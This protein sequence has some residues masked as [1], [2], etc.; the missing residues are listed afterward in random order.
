M[1]KTTL[2]IV[3]AAL[4]A[5]SGCRFGGQSTST[6]HPNPEFIGNPP[7]DAYKYTGEPGV[8]GGTLVIAIPDDIRTFN[9]V[10]ASDTAT[11]DV[12]WLNVFRCPVDFRN[13]TT[14]YDSGLCTKWDISADATQWT[15]HFRRGVLWS[16]GQ[17]FTAD[18]VIFTYD[19]LKDENV[20]GPSRD[21]FIESIGDD[22]KPIFP[23][24]IKLDDYTV[25]FD[26]HRSNWNFLD[27]IYNLWLVAKHKLE[28]AFNAGKFGETMRLTDDPNEIVSLGPFRIKEY[29][30]GQRV[31]VERNP[32]FWKVDSRGQRLPYLDRIV[33]VI[34]KDFNT[35]QAKFEAGDLDVMPRV[36]P[37]DY[38][39]VKRMESDSVKIADVGASYDTYW[40]VFNQNTDHNPSTGKP[41]VEPWKLRLF[42]D[43]KFRQAI[44]YAIDREG[45]ANTAFSAR[46]TPLYSF[47]SPADPIWYSDDVM[48]YP[49]DPA[50]SRQMLAELD[51]KDNNG[52]GILEDSQGHPL[53]FTLVTNASNSQRVNSATFIAGNLRD[54][55]IKINTNP[56]AFQIVNNMIETSFNFDAVLLGWQINP[57]PGPTN[58]KN[59]LLSSG[60]QHV[61]FPLQKQPQRDW[62]ARI[63]ELMHS[64]ESKPD[65]AERRRMYAEVQRIWS[66]QL[67]EINLVAPLEGIAYRTRV[68]NLHASVL[69]PRTTWNSEELYIR[70]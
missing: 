20:H 7:Q 68:G 6:G 5:V 52:D 70:Q 31:V 35:V 9:I 17:P 56:V 2:T 65:L 59:I 49:F 54:V 10:M 46:A 41:Y 30:S 36:R 25:R 43:Q 48:K 13:D 44:S 53:E 39:A 42:R 23:D 66:E 51:L 67:P 47:V 38:A 60:Q 3:I 15:F 16:D 4:L 1:I 63:D 33:F 29:V 11:A 45:L 55:G 27:A 8:Y 50:R 64:I 14:T 34:V 28:P 37:Q 57:P 62:E 26:L 61:C 32:Y 18:D 21:L 24:L 19:V 22:G 40:M 12:L 58:A 69:P